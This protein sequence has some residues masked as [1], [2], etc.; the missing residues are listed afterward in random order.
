[1]YM[2]TVLFLVTQETLESELNM[3][4]GNRPTNFSN[5]MY[6]S[7]TDPDV[8]VT[9]PPLPPPTEM[10]TTESTPPPA[11]VLPSENEPAPALTSSKKTGGFSPT[12]VDTDKDTQ[13]L[14]MEDDDE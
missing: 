1:M 6:E 11:D 2:L 12:S 3:N 8:A 9:T 14:V 7:F 4:K 13:A 10:T 5:P